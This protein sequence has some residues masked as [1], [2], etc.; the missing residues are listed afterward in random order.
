MWIVIGL[1]N[2]GIAY[3][4]SRHN[5][6]FNA[7]DRLAD[8][9]GIRVTKRGLSAVYGEGF[10]GTE[11]IVL[12]KPQTYMN[13]SG[14]SAEQ[15]LHFFKETPEH[16]IVIYDDIDLPVGSMRIRANGSAGTHNGMRSVVACVGTEMFPRIR[17]GMGEECRGELK[18]FVLSKPGK[19][20]QALLDEVYDHAAEAATLIVQGRI[21]DAQAR[22]NKKHE[23]MGAT[24]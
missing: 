14:D 4:N 9:L 2:P 21:N 15:V 24:N 5:A 18:D 23:G 17:I 19:A 7:L 16:M 11:K 1:G 3:Q 12:V 22:Y 20:E 13:L 6:G 10:F 8:K